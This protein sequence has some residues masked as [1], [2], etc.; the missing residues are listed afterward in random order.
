MFFPNSILDA[1]WPGAHKRFVTN[2]YAWVDVDV[3]GSGASYGYRTSI[4]PDEQ[5]QDSIEILD[6]IIRQPWSNGKVG[7]FGISFGGMTAEMLLA[8]KHPAVKAVAP[9][10]M[11]FDLYSD[12]S[13]PGGIHFEWGHKTWGSIVNGMDS[14]EVDNWLFSLA[15][16]GVRPVDADQDRSMLDKA[17][18]DHADNW[19]VYETMLKFTYRDD[20]LPY[21][22]NRNIDSFSPHAYV[23]DIKTSGVPIY[24]YT[25][26][27]DGRYGHAGIKRFLTVTNPGSKLIIGPWDHGGL[28]N[29]SPTVRGREK[30]DHISE[31]LRFFDYYLKGVD[32]GI[33][34]EKPVRYYTMVEDKWKFSDS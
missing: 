13:F 24:S 8:T 15:I 26:W 1:A 29:I 19:D 11:A 16:K 5:I 6:C 28:F 32:T 10:F 34:D 17:I 23:E 33:T 18:G 30:F 9:G 14:N 21:L 3:R 31:L 7:S 20:V 2:D 22:S 12:I 25:G 4:F 27:F